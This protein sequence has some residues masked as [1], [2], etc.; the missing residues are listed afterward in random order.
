MEELDRRKK[1]VKYLLGLF[2]V[3]YGFRGL[4]WVENEFGKII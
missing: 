3:F 4:S 2:E 1:D